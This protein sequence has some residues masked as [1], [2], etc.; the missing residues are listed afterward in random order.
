MKAELVTVKNKYFNIYSL[1]FVISDG[2]ILP[3][4]KKPKVRGGSYRCVKR[5]VREADHSVPS[6]TEVISAPSVR[7]YGV[8]LR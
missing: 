5:P 6:I 3:Y 4:R 2:S 8:V 7:L 1:M